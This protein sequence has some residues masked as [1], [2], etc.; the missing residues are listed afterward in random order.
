MHLFGKRSRGITPFLAEIII[1]LF[2]AFLRISI[3]PDI[4]ESFVLCTEYGQQTM[5][6]N[7]LQR[8]GIIKIGT[9]FHSFLTGSLLCCFRHYT[10]RLEDLA[11]SLTNR[12]RL[13]QAFCND[14]TRTGKRIF[15]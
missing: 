13:T 15:H 2:P 11:E 5:R 4:N 8:F 14:I 10:A 6:G 7:A 12:S 9:V 1:D 3:N